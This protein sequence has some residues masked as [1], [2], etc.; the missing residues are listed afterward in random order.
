MSSPIQTATLGHD[1]LF[2]NELV[3]KDLKGTISQQDRS[4]LVAD[5]NRWR[6]QL[7]CLKRRTEMQFTSSKAR[8]FTLYKEYSESVLSYPEYIDKL[9]K[10]K[11]WRCNAARFLQQIEVRIQEIRSIH[12]VTD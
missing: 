10:E 11:E 4:I 8:S 9:S 2:F 6:S 12:D 7:I 3:D 5:S 1:Q